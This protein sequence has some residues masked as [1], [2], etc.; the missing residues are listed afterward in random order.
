MQNTINWGGDSSHLC[1]DISPTFSLACQLFIAAIVEVYT[2]LFTF[3]HSLTL[4]IAAHATLY[5]IHKRKS[6]F[7]W[8]IT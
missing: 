5:P 4:S 8:N 2:G 6:F 7:P 1:F 3:I